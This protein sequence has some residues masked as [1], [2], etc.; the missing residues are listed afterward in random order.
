M[1]AKGVA[2]LVMSWPVSQRLIPRTPGK[3]DG[4]APSSCLLLPH[5]QRGVS[6]HSKHINNENES[7][8]PL[9]ISLLEHISNIRQGGDV[10]QNFC[11]VGVERKTK[12][13][14]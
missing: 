2:R 14:F 12:H 11:S 7:V 13:L 10:D 9:L 3:L 8:Q 5:E 6:S 4:Q 1:Q